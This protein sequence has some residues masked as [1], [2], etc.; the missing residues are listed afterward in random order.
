[1]DNRSTPVDVAG[2]ADPVTAISG[3]YHTCAVAGGVVCWGANYLAQLGDGARMTTPPAPV[4]AV[5]LEAAS[6]LWPL[7]LTTIALLPALAAS[8]VGATATKANLVW[9]S[10]ILILL[11]S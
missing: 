4:A 11:M 10:H 9:G 6:A 3:G 8:N 7:G 2:L 5:G 1:M